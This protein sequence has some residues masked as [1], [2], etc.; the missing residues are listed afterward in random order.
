MNKV[1]FKLEQ[2]AA[3]TGHRKV[4]FGK[5]HEVEQKLT[6]TI[7][8]HY[9]N[10]IRDFLCG[11]AIGF[12]MVAAEA[13]TNLKKELPYIR[14]IAVVPYRGQCERWTATLQNKYRELLN[15]ADR[16]I[17]LS[18]RYFNGC[19][20]RRND[21]LLANTNHIIAF[22][23][24]KEQGGTYYTTKKAKSSNKRITNIY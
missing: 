15:Q 24:G 12:D 18:E 3:F 8:E 14:L 19:L 11:M 20:L 1:F 21:F 2:S 17:I 6:E 13:V 23:N 5:Q 9:K 10:G 7:R 22:F 4:P 16:I